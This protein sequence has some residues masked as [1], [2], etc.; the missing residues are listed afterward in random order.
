MPAASQPN[1]MGRQPLAPFVER[2][3]GGRYEVGTQSLGQRPELEAV[4]GKCLMAWPPAE[5]EMA[6]VLAQL[7]GASESEAVLAVFHSLRRSTAQ[8]QAIS[9]AARI[10][11][12]E[13][14]RAKTLLD[15][16]LVV[17]KSTETDRND[18]THGHFGIYSNLP[19][20][21]IWMATHAY[22]DFKAR[23]ELA[24]QQ[25]TTGAAQELRARLFFYKKPD[26]D[27]ILENITDIADTWHA[28][29][30]YLRSA[31]PLRAELYRQLCDRSRI[32]QALD[33]RNRE[34]NPQAPPG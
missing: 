27:R 13:D 1:N 18:L 19:D 7:L 33:R 26:L 3:P 6:L 24:R 30:T 9:E 25:F 28:F 15:A 34:T 21:I 16:V 17:H 8:Y 22:V 12:K 20:G 23:M 14:E 2:H 5:A 32:R 10:A 29:T 31:P 4:I 11:L